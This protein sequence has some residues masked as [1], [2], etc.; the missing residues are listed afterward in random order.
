MFCRF[1][2]VSKKNSDGLTW[3]VDLLYLTILSHKFLSTVAQ[4]LEIKCLKV[5]M[6]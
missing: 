3:A 5:H 1:G 2:V 6:T 4:S